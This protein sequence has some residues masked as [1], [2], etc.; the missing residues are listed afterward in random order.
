MGLAGHLCGESDALATSFWS[1]VLDFLLGEF[2]LEPLACHLALAFGEC[3]SLVESGSGAGG[4]MVL[5]AGAKVLSLGGM[6]TVMEVT[7]KPL[8]T[9]VGMSKP[10]C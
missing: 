7:H 1:L 2:T 4:V 8:S 6:G 3:A 9:Y 5:V 10:Y